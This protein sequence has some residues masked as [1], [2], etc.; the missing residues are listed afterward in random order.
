MAPCS[1]A[2]AIEWEKVESIRRDAQRYQV[3]ARRFRFLKGIN[4]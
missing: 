2:L 3:A 1:S 4:A